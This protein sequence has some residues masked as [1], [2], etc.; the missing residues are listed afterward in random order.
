[1][2]ANQLFFSFVIENE[3]LPLLHRNVRWNF[4]QSHCLRS[5]KYIWFHKIQSNSYDS[6][7]F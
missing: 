1:M 5:S 6:I 7:M 2:S 3:E 4:H